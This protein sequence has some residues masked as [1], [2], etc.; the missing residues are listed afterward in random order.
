VNPERTETTPVRG[1][2]CQTL[3]EQACSGGRDMPTLSL[4]KGFAFKV[5]R[6]VRFSFNARSQL[7]NS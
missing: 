2:I 4:K 1:Q 5:A 6:V 7:R 3:T